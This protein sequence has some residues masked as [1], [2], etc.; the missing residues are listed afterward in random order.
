MTYQNYIYKT[1]ESTQIC[2][3]VI[4][5]FFNLTYID[6]NFRSILTNFNRF[7]KF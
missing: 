5:L 4:I 6:D 2:R 3:F 7:R 1:E